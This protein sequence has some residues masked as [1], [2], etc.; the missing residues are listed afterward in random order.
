MNALLLAATL[1]QLAL[2]PE[3]VRAPVAAECKI[4]L[5]TYIHNP[6]YS[7]GREMVREECDY[8]PGTVAAMRA[9]QLQIATEG[10][11]SYRHWEDWGTWYGPSRIES[12]EPILQPPCR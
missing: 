5:L 7:D 8:R 6:L 4:C 10:V 11:Y 3:P 1:G 9:R 2:P 12:V